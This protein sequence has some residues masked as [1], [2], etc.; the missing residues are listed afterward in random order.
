MSNLLA[1]IFYLFLTSVK[2]MSDPFGICNNDL[3]I[4]ELLFYVQMQAS[5]NT[6]LLVFIE[7]IQASL[8]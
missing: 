3:L 4:I 1:S 2:I 6:S 7:L 5:Y 8:H